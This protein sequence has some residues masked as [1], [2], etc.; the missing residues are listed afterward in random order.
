MAIEFSWI[1]GVCL[2]LEFPDVDLL[3]DEDAKWLAVLDLFIL[4][5][6]FIKY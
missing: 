5:F 3:E 2:G 6:V 4:R 1:S